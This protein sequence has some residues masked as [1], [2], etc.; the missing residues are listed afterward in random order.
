MAR[1]LLLS[2][3]NF[4]SLGYENKSK[5]FKRVAPYCYTDANG[6]FFLFFN[7]GGKIGTLEIP[8]KTVLV[9]IFDNTPFCSAIVYLPIDTLI[10]SICSMPQ[11]CIYLFFYNTLTAFNG[12]GGDGGGEKLVFNDTHLTDFESLIWKIVRPLN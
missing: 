6:W 1:K 9:S 4:P 7:R 8:I 11:K 5:V 3:F 10:R 12:S 2:E